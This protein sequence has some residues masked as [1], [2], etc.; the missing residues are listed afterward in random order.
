[1]TALAFT[2]SLGRAGVPVRVYSQRRW[3]VARF[4]KHCGDFALCPDPDDAVRFLPWLEKELRSGR[5]ELVAPTSDLI[6]FYLAELSDAIAGELR[7]R[8]PAPT[9]VL[10]SLFKNR[11]DAACARLGFRVPRLRRSGPPLDGLRA[12]RPGPGP[13]HLRGGADPG[14]ANRR[15]GRDRLEP[16][17][18]RL[19][20]LR[21]GAEQRSA[22]AL[23]PASHGRRGRAG[24]SRPRRPGLDARG[25]LPRAAP[26][27]LAERPAA[28]RVAGRYG[29]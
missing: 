14:S 11:F 17:G 28:A 27:E 16:A 3:P 29:G 19:H 26:G 25:P 8:L 10:E 13:R 7:R 20:Q 12:G 15:P 23:V 24:R 22:P 2:R 9:A 21:R 18:A 4:S 6:A 5:I 1:P